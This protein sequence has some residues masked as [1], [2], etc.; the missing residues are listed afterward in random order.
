MVILNSHL[1]G[2][3]LKI[4]FCLSNETFRFLKIL[5]TLNPYANPNVKNQDIILKES[6]V[7]NTVAKLIIWPSL[8]IKIYKY[9]QEKKLSLVLYFMAL[10]AKRLG[11]PEHTAPQEAATNESGLI[12]RDETHLLS[13]PQENSF[14][15]FRVRYIY[16]FLPN[17]FFNVLFL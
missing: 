16:C 5:F 15:G 4:N 9:C 2:T 7:K 14:Q 8:V 6:Y 1:S 17:L 10:P 12:L 3:A 13:L 11:A